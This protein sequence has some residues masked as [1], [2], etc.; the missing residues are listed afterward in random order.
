MLPILA[1]ERPTSLREALSH[2]AAPA[3][4]PLAG[5]TDLLGCLRDGI[6][7][8]RNLVALSGIRELHG[9]HSLADGGLRLGAMT[10]LAELAASPL[11]RERY[12]ALAQGAEAAASPQIRNQ[13][14][15]GG[16]LCQRPRCW[17]LRGG[18]QCR[19]VGG[20]ICFAIDG[21]NEYHCIFG[22][23]K[24]FVVHP[25][26]T[27]PALAAL[28]ARLRI[29]GLHE[30]REVPISSFF[31]LPTEDCTKENILR[32][33]E[34]VTAILLPPPTGLQSSYR[35]VRARAAWDFALAGVAVAIRLAG[36]RVECAHIVLSGVAP[37]PWRAEAAERSLVGEDLNEV[38]AS[39]AADASVSGAEPMSQNGFKIE[40]V[41][42]LVEEALLALS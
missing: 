19:K 15:I 40:L 29:V 3:A 28:D 22:G 5:G 10:T 23:S 20:D 4:T 7:A 33:R 17:Y 37:V 26:D 13:G 24:C 11:I 42:G 31:L 39:R 27:A 21:E 16:N 32:P 34:I 14:T 8:N 1:V 30:N 35:K 36:R 41:R 18:F 38:S 12:R 25:S 2:L 9:I 6:S